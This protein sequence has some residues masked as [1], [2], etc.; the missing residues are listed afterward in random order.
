[1]RTT[2]VNSIGIYDTVWG[3]VYQYSTNGDWEH[4][5]FEKLLSRQATYIK[6]YCW[7]YKVFNDAQALKK[8]E[9]IAA[10]VNRFLSATNG[11]FYNAQDA[12]LIPGEK[13]KEYFQLNDEQRMRKGIPAIDSNVY[14]SDNAQFAEALT[15]LWA[16]TDN[17]TYL[18]KAAK[19]VEFL[20]A[21]RKVKGAYMHGGKYTSTI[22]LKDNVTM[23][24]TLLLVYRATQNTDYKTEA[25]QLAKTITSTFNSGKGY[26]YT[27]IG[28]SAIR[29]TYNV[30]ENIEVCRV[31]NYCAHFFDVPDYKTTATAVLDFL[32]NEQLVH[33][34]STEP[35]ILSAAEELSYEPISAALLLKNGDAL[36]VDYITTSISFPRFYFNSSIYTKETIT[37]DKKDLF[38]SLDGNCIVLCTS[39]YCSAPMFNQKD[40]VTFLYKRV[41]AN[42]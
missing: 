37:E 29:A 20:N 6:M 5:H 13:A 3:G 30:S 14:T 33:S 7:Y 24:K 41:F 12:D 26:F 36:K 27:Y 19:C 1:L 31:L 11:G 32:T 22:S 34:Y 28:N 25:A 16:T 17:Q 9:G 38:E 21:Q 2:V 18:N 8:A 15:I 23:L 35:G 40:F 4:A 39:S 10:Y 42:K